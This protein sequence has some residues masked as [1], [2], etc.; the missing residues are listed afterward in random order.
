[1]DPGPVQCER[2]HCD[3]LHPHAKD[4][5]VDQLIIT[6]LVI[7]LAS[8]SLLLPT[9]L[10]LLMYFCRSPLPLLTESCCVGIRDKHINPIRHQKTVHTLT[11]VWSCWSNWDIDKA[12]SHPRS[13]I[14]QSSKLTPSLAFQS[15]HNSYTQVYDHC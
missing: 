3:P 6:P 2:G 15:P 8:F 14:C 4:T 1:M 13:A 7:T 9:S 10:S 5:Q 11:G 12:S